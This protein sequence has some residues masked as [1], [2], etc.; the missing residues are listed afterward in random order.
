M[1]LWLE[2]A[3]R[4]RNA[5]WRYVVATPLALFVASVLGVLLVLALLLAHLAS[6]EAI[7]GISDP[8]RPVPFFI[9]VFVTFGLLLAGFVAAPWLVQGKRF[10]D[11]LG[12]WRWRAVVI[13]A[14]V[15]G[16]AQIVATA[17]DL[18]VAPHAL[19]VSASTASLLL[20]LVATPALAMQ[21][22]TEEFVFRGYIT[23]GLFLALRRPLP[24]SVLSGAIFAA[25]HIPNGAPQALSALLFG[26][27]IAFAAMRTGS[28]ALGFGVHLA[29]NLFGSVVVV[30]DADVFKGAP[31][32][33]TEHAPGLI[34]W[35]VGVEAALLALL[36]LL[37]TRLLP[38]ER[39][40][41]GDR[42]RLASESI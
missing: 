40:V 34:W 28:L 6:P 42:Q 39:V 7:A 26:S 20:A 13:G 17:A 8:S 30:S 16:L 5:L 9:G 3:A 23:Q 21:T 25:A 11:M 32:L 31:A 14:G 12:R 15:W 19:R 29:N 27:V 35:D 22:F 37:L 4:G 1:M 41:T 18:V 2:Y 36:A 10:G 33:I 38:P 24:T